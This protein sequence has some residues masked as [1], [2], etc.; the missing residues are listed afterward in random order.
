M[1][2]RA[3]E[4]TKELGLKI[5][6]PTKEARLCSGE[7]R[8]GVAVARALQFEAELVILDEPT[9]GLTL[10]GIDRL[11][12]YVKKM[13]KKGAGC[14]FI[15]HNFR[16]I[17][18]FADRFVILARGKVKD[19]FPNKNVSINMLED[20]MLNRLSDSISTSAPM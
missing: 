10:E 16:H 19:A 2:K 12:K 14:I 6:S 1:R 3:V 5:D 8:Q 11:S 7:E 20:L 9:V 4:L 18:D 17:I 13:V 15:T